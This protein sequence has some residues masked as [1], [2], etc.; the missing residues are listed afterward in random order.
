MMRRRR[1]GAAL[2]MALLVI[3][4]LDCI[5][6]GSLYLALQEVRIGGNGSAVLQL[7]LDAE[8]GVRRALGLWTL[9]VDTMPAGNGRLM[10]DTLAT[11][12]ARVHVE[13][14][15][16]LLF[17]L[18]SRAFERPP[19]VGRAAAG[20][21]VAPPA[22][23]VGVDPAPAP[24]SSSG[25]VQVSATGVVVSAVPGGCAAAAT[26]HAILAPP[27]SITSASGA[28]VD[29]PG[30]PLGS[31]P[32]IHTF[33]RLL[34]LAPPHAVAAGDSAIT[35]GHSGILVVPGNLTIT[36]GAI[37]SGLL[38]ASGAVHVDPGAVVTGAVHAGGL[39]TVGGTVMWDPCGVKAAVHAAGLD[40]P[41]P[42]AVRAWLP[43]F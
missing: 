6:L 43:A 29:A 1:S 22:L 4:I 10:F 11:A 31:A 16:D 13:R 34:A 33:A 28:S 41:R 5:V 27:F 18:E 32:L 38:V 35:T 24:L 9:E 7:R 15:D 42:A 23:A 3:V 21:L 37:V 2:T 14:L 26:P 12:G 39:L 25:S 20:M 30:G 17:L 19:R 36:G 40:R 8:S